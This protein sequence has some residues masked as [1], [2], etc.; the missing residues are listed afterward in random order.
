MA[1]P[2]LLRTAPIS[3]QPGGVGFACVTKKAWYG[4]PSQSGING[5]IRLAGFGIPKWMLSNA[6]MDTGASLRQ[7]GGKRLPL[8]RRLARNALAFAQALRHLMGAIGALI[9]HSNNQRD[10]ALT[11]P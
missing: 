8:A 4:F 5:S 10:A 7:R 6:L 9:Q 2:A 3:C 11:T 1:C